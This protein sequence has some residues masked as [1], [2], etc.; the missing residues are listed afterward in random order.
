MKN[1]YL[2]ASVVLFLASLAG[3]VYLVQQNQDT[4]NQAA[5]PTCQNIEPCGDNWVPAGRS[6]SR[7]FEVLYCNDGQACKFIREK[8]CEGTE[9]S[10]DP[11]YCERSECTLNDKICKGAPYSQNGFECEC[12]CGDG[13]TVWN[14]SSYN[15][16][17][18]PPVG[19]PTGDKC[20]T[21]QNVIR[22]GRC[23]R[24]TSGTLDVVNKYSC[25]PGQDASRG[26]QSNV[27]TF[28]NVTEVCVDTNLCGTQQIDYHYPGEG[29]WESVTNDDCTSPTSPPR[30]N[31]KPSATSTPKPTATSTPKPSATATPKPSNTPTPTSTPKPTATNTPGP[32]ATG[33]LTPTLTPTNTPVPTNTPQPTATNTPKPNSTSTPVPTEVIAQG[34]SPTRIVLPQAGFEFPVQILTVLGAIVTLA[35]FLILL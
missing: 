5:L 14:C 2:I 18:C 20:G 16:S 22:D 11:S 13:K 6:G 21:I 31:P 34:P 27:Q 9:P 8:D 32:T 1:I 10:P 7:C 12:V 30:D 25:P 35:G 15:P 19:A 4:R 23:I 17:S 24:A 3:V 28:R 26:C 33:T 29:C